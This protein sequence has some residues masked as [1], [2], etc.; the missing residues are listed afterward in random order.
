MKSELGAKVIGKASDLMEDIDWP[1]VVGCLAVGAVVGVLADYWYRKR[2]AREDDGPKD[3][4][5]AM[6][7]P[8]L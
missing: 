8:F 1:L 6:T 2:M 5:M 4:R 3:Q 7:F